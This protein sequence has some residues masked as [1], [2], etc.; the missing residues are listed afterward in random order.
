MLAASQVGCK[1]PGNAIAELYWQG[2]RVNFLERKRARL[3]KSGL[4]HL[5]KL[6]AEFGAVTLDVEFKFEPQAPCVPI[7]RAKKR[8][9]AIDDHE[10][11]MIELA[12]A[13][14]HTAAA[15]E[16]L[17]KLTERGP[18]HIGE[19]GMRRPMRT[20][21][22]AALSAP[23]ITQ[24][25]RSKLSSDPA[26]TPRAIIPSQSQRILRSDGLRPVRISESANLETALRLSRDSSIPV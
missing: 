15:L 11:R 18:M 10:L 16:H 3:G 5:C 14:P 8:P 24:R 19:I 20:E 13:Q 25:N 6:A 1:R 12:G 9:F 7:G 2:A 26:S 22:R 4:R 23:I 21:R 17:P